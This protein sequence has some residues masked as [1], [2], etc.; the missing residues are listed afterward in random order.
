MNNHGCYLRISLQGMNTFLCVISRKPFS[1]TVLLPK[2]SF[3]LRVSS[4]QRKER[5]LWIMKTASFDQLYQWQRKNLQAEDEFFLHDG[6]PYA[7]GKPHMG[8]AL[9]KI[10]K[11][12]LLRYNLLSGKLV[13]YIPGWDCHGLPIEL[14]ALET[15]DTQKSSVLE[16]RQKAKLFALDTIKC[17]KAAFSRW[18]VLADW[19]DNCYFTFSPRYVTSQLKMFCDLFDKGLVYRDYKPVYWS[20]SAR[21]AL[22]ESELEYNVNH[23]STSVYVKLV[24]HTPLPE[25]I[26]GVSKNTPV[27]LVVWTT[28]PWT[29]PANQAVCFHPDIKYCLVRCKSNVDHEYMVVALELYQSLQQLWLRDLTVVKE[30]YGKVLKG[31]FYLHPIQKTKKMPLLPSE[32]VTVKKGTGLVHTSP[33]HGPDDFLVA[34][35][36]KLPILNLVDEKGRYSADAGSDLAGYNVLDKGQDVVLR[37]LGSNVVFLE[38]FRHSYPYDWR[39][40]Q[41]VILRASLQWFVDTEKIKTAAIEAMKRVVVVPTNF[42]KTML[43]QL[44]SRPYWCI[45]RQRSWGVP[46]PVFYNSSLPTKNAILHRGVV[47]RLCELIMTNGIDQ[48]WLQSAEDLIGSEI[49]RELQLLPGHVFKGM[50]IMDI[51]FDS[52]AS[53]NSVL[54]EGKQ[55]DFYLEGI[56]QFGGW[57]QSSLLTSVACRDHAPYK[58]IFV[59]GFVLDHEGRKMSKSLGNVMDP[60][61]VVDGDGNQPA[62]GIDALR[63]WVA[64]HVSGNGSNVSVSNQLIQQASDDVQKIRSVIRFILGNLHGVTDFQLQQTD[65]KNLGFVDLYMLHLLT[66][67]VETT[68]LAYRELNFRKVTSLLSYFISNNVSAFY[69][70]I[71]RGRLYCDSM[72]SKKR[73]S[74]LYVLSEILDQ[75]SLITAPILPHLTEEIEIYHPWR[76]GKG[77]L[78]RNRRFTNM[79][80]FESPDVVECIKPSLSIRNAVNKSIGQFNT[81]QWNVEITAFDSRDLRFLQKLQLKESDENSELCELLQVSTV[82]LLDKSVPD[83]VAKEKENV[84]INEDNLMKTECHY[85]GPIQITLSKTKLAACP[86]CRRYTSA[87]GKLCHLC[88]VVAAE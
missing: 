33:A 54:P 15:Y 71:V 9:N 58:N 46:I 19:N 67:F 45:S 42:E 64:S 80:N 63:W 60:L 53:W 38:N 65:L 39:T 21:T 18:G 3:P 37:L 28:T 8:H 68:F 14:K 29:L 25:C 73:L 57:F 83:P 24:L 86:R 23:V 75:V 32:H 62:V 74:A 2:T 59:H 61:S 27:Y 72:M 16:I 50:D 4:K 43:K 52:G 10:L 69:C 48:W 1:S 40:K 66:D 31:H 87:D 13:H 11:D 12:I 17:Q 76:S 82:T 35:E 81:Q 77:G 44:A 85:S 22:A 84:S 7:N 56:D 30:F 55:A 49:M 36:H 34:L 79:R 47:E 78:F 41:P 26:I 70:N 5:D 6:P 51:W 88:L 20:P